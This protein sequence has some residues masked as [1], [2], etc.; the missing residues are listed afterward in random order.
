M[1]LVGVGDRMVAFRVL[2][3]HPVALARQ[4]WE[5]FSSV[6]LCTDKL[7]PET[8][9]VRCVEAHGIHHTS[10][11]MTREPFDRVVVCTTAVISSLLESSLIDGA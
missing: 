9:R 11:Y 7:L 2:C 5:T 10:V 6:E 1:V 8:Q 4:N 3:I